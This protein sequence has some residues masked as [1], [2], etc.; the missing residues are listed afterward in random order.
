MRS[1]EQIEHTPLNPTHNP[2][3]SGCIQ[4]RDRFSECLNKGSRSD[5]SDTHQI[6]DDSTQCV[7]GCTDIERPYA[8]NCQNRLVGTK[9]RFIGAEDGSPHGGRSRWRQQEYI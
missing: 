4:R 7:V 3:N 1:G 2:S 8:E 6:P 9:M 5:F